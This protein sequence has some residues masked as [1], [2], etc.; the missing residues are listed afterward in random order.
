VNTTL[1]TT[2]ENGK[3]VLSVRGKNS[4]FKE[5]SIAQ[6]GKLEALKAALA[7]EVRNDRFCRR[8]ILNIYNDAFRQRGQRTPSI[9]DLLVQNYFSKKPEWLRWRGLKRFRKVMKHPKF[10]QVSVLLYTDICFSLSL[11]PANHLRSFYP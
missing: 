4:L 7:A 6:V 2:G 9:T 11:V 10:D 1:S 8:Y 3:E 5:D